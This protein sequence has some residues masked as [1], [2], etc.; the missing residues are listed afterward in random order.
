MNTLDVY[1]SGPFVGSVL[2]NLHIQLITHSFTQYRSH[3]AI[4]DGCRSLHGMRRPFEAIACSK[5][6]LLRCMLQL[7]RHQTVHA[8]KLGALH[9]TE[10]ADFV[11]LSTFA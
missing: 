5:R 7:E 8:C 1:S 3:V 11:E 6:K 9:C 10:F 2:V 4:P